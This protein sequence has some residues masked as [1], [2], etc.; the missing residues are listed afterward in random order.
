MINDRLYQ[1]HARQNKLAKAEKKYRQ[2]K[3]DESIKRYHKIIGKPY[4]AD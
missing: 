4:K 2:K 1:E 3:R